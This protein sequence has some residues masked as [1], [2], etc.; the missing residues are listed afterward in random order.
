MPQERPKKKGKNTHTQKKKFGRPRFPLERPPK[1]G[2]GGGRLWDQAPNK[3]SRR[4]LQV[5]S[6]RME[7]NGR[8]AVSVH[9]ESL[10]VETP[11]QVH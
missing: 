10:G 7:S 6:V 4:Q 5:A 2:S 1:V 3:R 9:G 11:R 8:T